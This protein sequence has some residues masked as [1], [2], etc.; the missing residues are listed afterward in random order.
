MWILYNFGETLEQV[1]VKE[2]PSILSRY[3]IDLAKAYSSFYNEN[4][5]IGESEEIQNARA[6]ITYATGKVLKIGV[7]LLGMQ[8]PDKM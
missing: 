1:T 8:M 5:I 6:Y 2:E 4:K 3:L 7:E